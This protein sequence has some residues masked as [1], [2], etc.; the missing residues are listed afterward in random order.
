ME[1]KPGAHSGE[2][3][4]YGCHWGRP[5]CPSFVHCLQ[6]CISPAAANGGRRDRM[7]QHWRLDALV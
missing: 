1:Q 7:R 6:N 3:G 2:S 5:R 4:D